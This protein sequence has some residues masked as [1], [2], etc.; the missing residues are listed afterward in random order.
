MSLIKKE[1]LE[2]LVCPVDKNTLRE[3][4]T[5]MKLE[6]SACGRKYPVREGI[7]V[8]LIDEAEIPEK[9]KS[10]TTNKH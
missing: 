1:H 8:M 5:E 9:T 6:C 4:D 10:F 2:I 7:P 3:L